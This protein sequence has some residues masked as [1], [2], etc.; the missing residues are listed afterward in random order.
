MNPYNVQSVAGSEG[1]EHVQG[2]R[3]GTASLCARASLGSQY[4]QR[5]FHCTASPSKFLPLVQKED[6]ETVTAARRCQRAKFGH[7]SNSSVNLGEISVLM[8]LKTKWQRTFF[9]RFTFRFYITN[10]STGKNLLVFQFW[11]LSCQC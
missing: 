5:E 8:R 2:S 9:H 7:N 10:N 1:F 3:A 6:P 4:I 11:P